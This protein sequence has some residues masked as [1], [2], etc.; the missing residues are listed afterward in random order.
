MLQYYIHF[1]DE[2]IEYERSYE[3]FTGS[4]TTSEHQSRDSKPISFFFLILLFFFNFILF[5]NFT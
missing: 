5:L 1:S 3:T 2:E 4:C